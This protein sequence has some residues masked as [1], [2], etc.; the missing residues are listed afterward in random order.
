MRPHTR[1]VFD[2]LYRR[3]FTTSRSRFC[4]A[5]RLEASYK[6]AQWTVTLASV[7]LIVIP[8]I[9]TLSLPSRLNPTLLNL[10]EVFFAIVIL[11]FSL[12]TSADNYLVKA[13]RMHRGALELARVY[14]ALEP[15][16]KKGGNL[17]LYEQYCSRYDDILAKY[18][19]HEPIDYLAFTLTRPD[20]FYDTRRSLAWAG[21]SYRLQAIWSRRSFLF[22]ILLCLGII[23]VVLYP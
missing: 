11:A 3:V 2:E 10:L 22:L 14:K 19:N 17:H 8:L 4:A 5:R 13:D 1:N 7:A 18:E 9:Q 12:L 21:I 16:R 6:W 15:Y 20:M 23:R